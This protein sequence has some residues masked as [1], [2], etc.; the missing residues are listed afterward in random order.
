MSAV[1][2]S[3]L[4]L[5]GTNS[6]LALWISRPEAKHGR[7]SPT[8]WVLYVLPA[9]WPSP[10]ETAW[11][12]SFGLNLSRFGAFTPFCEQ[13]EVCSSHHQL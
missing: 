4:S 7:G 13:W 6:L 9:A 12:L 5:R 3:V 2:S 8:P 10:T 11:S 1:L